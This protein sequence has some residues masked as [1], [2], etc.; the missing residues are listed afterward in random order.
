[1]RPQ[2]IIEAVES[3]GS[4][5]SLNGE[6]LLNQLLERCEVAASEG[7]I[8]EALMDIIAER[9]IDVAV[10]GTHGRRAFKKLMMGSGGGSFSF[11]AVSGSDGR[12]ERKARRFV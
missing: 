5:V 3:G 10:M 11:G 6:R 12:H 1:M 2:E 4:R 7:T 9:H 8:S